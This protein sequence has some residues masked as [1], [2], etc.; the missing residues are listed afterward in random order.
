M[1]VLVLVLVLVLLVREGGDGI[2]FRGIRAR[3][4]DVEDTENGM[5]IA[6]EDLEKLLVFFKSSSYTLSFFRCL[7]SWLV[8]CWL[9]MC[10][11]YLDCLERVASENE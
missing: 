9:V 2:V 11:T 6:K 7:M 8:D 5:K 4:C 10:C 3:A 1:A